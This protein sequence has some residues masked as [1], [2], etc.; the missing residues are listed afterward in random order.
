MMIHVLHYLPG[1]PWLGTWRICAVLMIH[2]Y[3]DHQTMQKVCE[4]GAELQE[5]GERCYVGYLVV[6]LCGRE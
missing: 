4:G 3:D 1:C 6:G 5:G 2:C